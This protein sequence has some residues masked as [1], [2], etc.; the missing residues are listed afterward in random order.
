[1]AEMAPTLTV[2]IPDFDE[3]K[4]VGVCS[5]VGV[6]TGLLPLTMLLIHESK[7]ETRV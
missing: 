4:L 2:T 6:G 3:T 7:N 5:A 1:M